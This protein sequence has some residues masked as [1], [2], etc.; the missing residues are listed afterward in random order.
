MPRTARVVIPN[1]PHHIIQRGHNRQIIFSSDDDYLYY[2]DNLS[3][4]KDKLSCKVYSYCLMTNH[5]HLIID[6]G[7]EE[8]NLS[9]LM[10]RIAGRQT[11]LV[12]K[13]E[14]RTG[15]LW[16]GRYKSSPIS[17]NEYL[18]ACCRYVEMNPVRAGMVDE[19]GEYRWSSY[20]TKVGQDIEEWLDFDPYYMG[21]A[22][23][24]GKRA[25]KYAEWIKGSIPEGELLLIRQSLQRGQLT[26]S[27]RFVDE[28]EEKI[29]RRVEFRGQGRPGK[30]LK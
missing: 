6:P 7:E 21:L 5:V 25:D 20:R 30:V 28:V 9:K 18:L 11:R 15:S 26:G 8:N 24:K 2:L 10:K 22:H 13:V 16:E 19:P 14:K 1:Y 3:N 29:K 17:T 12:N 4:W 27:A 23:T